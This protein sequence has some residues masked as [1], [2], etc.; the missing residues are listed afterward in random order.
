MNSYKNTSPGVSPA[1]ASNE[2]RENKMHVPPAGNSNSYEKVYRGERAKCH[3][4]LKSGGMSAPK[5]NN[6]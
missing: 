2:I 6:K 1:Y 5:L 3:K 4:S